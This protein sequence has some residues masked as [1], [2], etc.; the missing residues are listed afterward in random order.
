MATETVLPVIDISQADRAAVG[1][2]LLDA[3][4]TLGFVF[5]EGSG[6]T[7]DEVDVM[8]QLSKDFFAQPFEAKQEFQ[9]SA[10]NRG[11]SCLGREVLDTAVGK[12]DPKEVF[13]FGQF[14]GGKAIQPLPQ[15]FAQSE[16]T[17]DDFTRKAHA[18]CH[19]IQNLLALALEIDPA[20]GG[21][22]WFSDRHDLSKFSGSILRM[23]YYPALQGTELAGDPTADIRAGAHT[24]FGSMTLLFQRDG[25]AALEVLSPVTKQWTPIP[26]LP[27]RD[28]AACPPIVLNIADQLSFWSAGLLKSAVHR[29]KFP[30]LAI[31][32]GK[33]RYSMAYF[34]HPADETLLEPMPSPLVQSRTGRGA[35]AQETVITAKEHLARRLAA[36]YGWKK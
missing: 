13:N 15:L 11:Y 35:N 7:A 29:V 24:D 20:A 14:L 10:E 22:T 5:I 16:Q 2:Q 18:V 32:G 17:L 6:F 30:S 34:C 1:K 9:I 12:S 33:D 19:K 26:A 8:F 28:S 25:Q 3:A 21:E 4:S 31:E 27:A 36:A 23:L